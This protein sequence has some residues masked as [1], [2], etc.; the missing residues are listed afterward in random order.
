MAYIYKHFIPQNIAPEG[1]IK[2]GVYDINDN[3]VCSIPLGGL[4]PPNEDKLYSFGLVSDIHLYKSSV[5]WNPDTKF[6]NALTYFESKGCALCVHCGDITQ[7]GLFNEG[8][9]VNK[10]VAQIA[11][12]DEI[13]NKHTINVYGIYG[14]HESYV[15]PIINNLSD[16]KVYTK[17]DLYYTVSHGND[18]FIF[19]GQP[20]GSIPMTD[21]ALQWLYNTLES[22][23][24]KRCFIF[25]H[26]HISSGNALGAYTSNNFFAGW[27][28]KTTAF[29]N[30]LKHYK[31]TIL[32]H[33]HS[34]IKYV[35]QEVDSQANYS[36]KDGFK[37]VHV[38][39]IG[40]PR[41]ITNGT[42]NS[43]DNAESEGYLVDV[44]ADYIVLNGY[45]F[46]DGKAIPIA[47]YK[48]DTKLIEIEAEMFG[49][50]TGIINT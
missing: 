18:L 11:K 36:E 23:R 27:G 15:V 38:S 49:D 45:D 17:T 41:D 50:S 12:Y 48:I 24:N 3:R 2:I 40:R 29:K 13:C 5:V 4:T 47:T 26:P 9:T 34:H 25:V 19:I 42:L 43:Y 46:I 20:K 16:I 21:E 8:D 44:Y 37:S 28:L 32:F 39:S 22:N 7:T 10:D 31:N 14:N 33:G 30:L 6:D 1:T 35:C